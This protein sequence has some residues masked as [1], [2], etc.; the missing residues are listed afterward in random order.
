MGNEFDPERVA[1]V[2]NTRSRD[3]ER[4]FF[5]ALEVLE[6]MGLRVEKTHPL[7]DPARLPETVRELVEEGCE[8]LILGGGDGTVSSVVD[9]LAG[10]ETVLGLLP[11]GTANDFAR[12]LEIPADMED[13]C[14]VI[15]HGE[16]V[17]VDLGVAGDDYFVNVASV[18]MGVEVTRAL[19]P[20]LKKRTGALAYPIAAIRAFL[21]HEPFSARLTFPGGDHEPVELER[22][23]QVAVGNGRFYGGGLVVAPDSEID[24]ETLDVYAIEMTRHRNLIGIAR[25]LRSGDFIREEGVSHFKTTEVHLETYPV[26]RINIDGEIGPSTPEIFRVERNALNVLVP[27]G[28]DAARRD[29]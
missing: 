11:L 26:Q 4:A 13:A 24:D 14:R 8:L 28:T 29:R 25:Y 21:R 9:F 18:G 22:L 15:V 19:S 10:R 12:T 16:V 1:L 5:R 3:G 6:E 17:D 27:P 2:V 23:L 20:Q 7:Q